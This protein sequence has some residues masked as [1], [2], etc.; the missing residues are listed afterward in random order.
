M[1]CCLPVRG[2]MMDSCASIV[3]AL[4]VGAASVGAGVWSASS[5]VDT[6]MDVRQ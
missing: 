6:R 4:R 3:D 1:S 5:L 2:A